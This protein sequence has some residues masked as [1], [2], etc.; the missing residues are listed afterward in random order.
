MAVAGDSRLNDAAQAGSGIT[1]AGA[2]CSGAS[3]DHT[4]RM[5]SLRFDLPWRSRLRLATLSRIVAEDTI[6]PRYPER[7]PGLPGGILATLLLYRWLAPRTRP[8]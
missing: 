6:V 3:P 5:T 2:L 7:G 8:S 4:A 1:R